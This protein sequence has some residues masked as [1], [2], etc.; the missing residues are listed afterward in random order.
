[1]RISKKLKNFINYFLGPALFIVIGLSIY[2]QIISKPDS[3][4]HWAEIKNSLQGSQSWKLYAVIALMFLNWGIESVKWKLLISHVM[5]V[6][7]LTAVKMVIS[8]VSFTMITP[9]RMGEFV[10][11][12]LYVP[13]GQRIK[14][15]TLVIISSTSQLIVTLLSGGIGLLFLKK[16]LLNHTQLLH[17]LNAVWINIIC[18]GTFAAIIGMCMFYFRISWLVRLIEK[19]PQLQRFAYFIQPLDNIS[20]TELFKVM[21]L[22]ILR[23]FVFIVQYVLLLQLF[24]VQISLANSVACIAVLFLFLALVPTVALA[25]LGI[26]AKFSTIIFGIFSSNAI[27]VLVT[28]FSIWIINIIFPAVAGSLLVLG[29]RLF[30]KE[31]NL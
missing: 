30:K 17:G 23:Y 27:G 18:Y 10:G 19:I 16:Y 25:E 1:L 2:N 24:G 20:A 21:F 26:R 29:V 5:H 13:D 28:A 31:E 6:S 7:F 22:S 11:R 4:S 9:N 12:V 3:A 15:A 8:G 14:A